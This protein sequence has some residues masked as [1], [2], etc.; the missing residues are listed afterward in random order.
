MSV[1]DRVNSMSLIRLIIVGII[2]FAW[3]MVCMLIVVGSIGAF[4]MHKWMPGMVDKVMGKVSDMMAQA[5]TGCTDESVEE[6]EY[7]VAD[8]DEPPEPGDTEQT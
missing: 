3:L 4:Q 5:Q 2:G 7:E 6:T 1:T 8:A